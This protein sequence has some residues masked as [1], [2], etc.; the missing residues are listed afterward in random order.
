MALGYLFA[1]LTGVFYGLQGT[2][3]KLLAGRY[4]APVLTWA[5][6]SFS[7]P[8]IGVFVV[9]LGIPP[10]NWVPFL[11]ATLTSFLVNVVAWN[12]F[13]RA[14]SVSSLAHTM[15]FTAFTPL[16]LIPVAFVLLG[17]L[18]D[19]RGVVGI[20]L[21]IAGAY[22][23]FLRSQN[24]LAPFKEMFRDKGT[25]Y[26]LIVA[27]IWAFSAT[28]EKVA[29]MNSSPEFYG[30][31]IT[32]LLGMAYFPYVW[33]A[34]PDY[35]KS[36][37]GHAL[38]FSVLGLISG[39]MVIFQFTALKFI[40]VSYVIAFK[41]A[42]VIISVY[43]GYVFFGEKGIVKNLLFTALMIVGVMFILFR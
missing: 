18:P 27:F 13:F 9:Y 31:V 32:S 28:V 7:T 1:I 3:S 12:L 39:L 4:P 42:G 2:Y 11:W 15:P 26:M 10:V 40:L 25:R 8:I 19:F 30:L 33:K 37:A 21:I 24:L 6:F 17:E 14:L 29:V 43:L 35:L 23:L 36:L 41:R 38:H 20:V 34:H 16:F 22:G 5:I